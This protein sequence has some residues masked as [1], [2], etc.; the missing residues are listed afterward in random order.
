[1][2]YSFNIDGIINI[3]SNDINYIK[4][5]YN[6]KEYYEL[7]QIHSNII[8]IVDNNYQN[9]TKGDALITNKPNT[10]L[11]IRTADCIPILLY[12]K[13]NKVIALVHSG[14]KGTLNNIV[15]DTLNIMIEKYHSKKGD[16]SVYLYPAIRKC[17]FE[18]EIDVYNQFKNKINNIEKYTTRKGI[19]YY[20][21]LEHLVIDNLKQNN[22]KEI[23]D[24]KICTYCNHD[25]YH[26]YRYNHT[27]KRNYLLV[28]IKE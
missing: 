6:I 26:S 23:Y 10:P 28:M 24:S 4:E 20:I 8:N 16:I 5:K 2:E 9:K 14:W 19:K 18:V 13:V 7:E 3:F 15:I 27:N 17:H 25:K 12:D 11:V 21:D 22:I 1:M